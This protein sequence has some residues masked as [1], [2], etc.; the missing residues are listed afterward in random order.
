MPETAQMPFFLDAVV[1][2]NPR[3]LSEVLG[4]EQSGV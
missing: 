3:G 1:A 4:R 2:A